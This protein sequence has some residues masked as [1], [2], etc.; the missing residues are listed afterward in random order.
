MARGSNTGKGNYPA[1][2]TPG[3][4]KTVIEGIKSAKSP[5]FPNKHMST[6]KYKKLLK[7]E[8]SDV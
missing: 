3:N 4:A 8:E 6:T 7:K 2:K 1:G 5:R